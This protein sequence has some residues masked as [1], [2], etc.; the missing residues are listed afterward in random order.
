MQYNHTTDM[1]AVEFLHPENT[2]T[3]PAQGCGQTRK[4]WRTRP[5]RNPV[6]LPAGSV[7]SWEV[8]LNSSQS[9]CE[10]SGDKK[11]DMGAPYLEQNA[12]G[13]LQQV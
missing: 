8:L 6:R 11:S 7:E 5:T 2:P 1:D 10:R 3:D 12:T 9:I 4:L 13:M